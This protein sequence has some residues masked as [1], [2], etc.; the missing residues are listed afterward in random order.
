MWIWLEKNWHKKNQ[1][2][3]ENIPRA[4]EI[5]KPYVTFILSWTMIAMA[6]YYT[7]HSILEKVHKFAFLRQRAHYYIIFEPQKWQIL[8]SMNEKVVALEKKISLV[9]TRKW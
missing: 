8:Q 9:F 7:R 2:I 3:S 4:D 5:F 1:I 6:D